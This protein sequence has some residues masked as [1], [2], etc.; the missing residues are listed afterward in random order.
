M[1]TTET[2]RAV[3][4]FGATGRIGS[5]IIRALTAALSSSSL[6]IHAATRDVSSPRA[7]LWK[8]T[9]NVHLVHADF[10]NP[11]S[12][13]EALKGVWG[14]V[15]VT[16]WGKGDT[17]KRQGIAV[18][19]AAS[20]AGVSALVYI[21]DPTLANGTAVL[22]PNKLPIEEHVLSAQIPHKCVLR[23]AF[24]YETFLRPSGR[25]TRGSL[26]FLTPT[27][28]V[29]TWCALDDVGKAVRAYL[30]NPVN[31]SGTTVDLVGEVMS[32]ANMAKHLS[33]LTGAPWTASQSPPLFLIRLV[34]SRLYQ[35]ILAVATTPA[36]S[37]VRRIVLTT[38]TLAYILEFNRAQPP[39][40]DLLP[41]PQTFQG[42]CTV[43]GVGSGDYV[44]DRTC[45]EWAMGREP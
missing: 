27:D 9:P 20:K 23:P 40:P 2:N 11:T 14:V 30:Q 45:L 41:E 34:S 22:N 25:L 6:E 33:D 12:L 8:D 38:A 16:V 32:V 35:A 4:V 24:Y 17:E 13:D 19:D 10:D 1:E 28:A 21:S 5:A 7:A 31:A 43:K 36:V 37:V 39:H 26:S 29:V 44:W 3:L 18:V 42:W 15:L